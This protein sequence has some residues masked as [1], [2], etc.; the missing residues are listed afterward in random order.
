MGFHNTVGGDRSS[1]KVYRPELNAAF[2]WVFACPEYEEDRNLWC[3]NTT[4]VCTKMY[5][6]L[7]NLIRGQRVCNATQNPAHV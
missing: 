1:L 3:N 7:S 6:V 2:D 5:G 4:L